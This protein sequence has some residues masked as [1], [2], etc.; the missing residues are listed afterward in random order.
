MFESEWT[1]LLKF[2]SIIFV[3]F[4]DDTIFGIYSYYDVRGG[5]SSWARAAILKKQKYNQD[6]F[7]AP[8]TTPYLQSTR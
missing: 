3:T 8:R 6:K 2:G 4:L 7:W 1:S 5:R